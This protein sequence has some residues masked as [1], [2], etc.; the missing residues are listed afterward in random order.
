MLLLAAQCKSGYVIPDPVPGGGSGQNTETGNTDVVEPVGE[1]T[2][3]TYH[4]GLEADGKDADTYSLIL[5]R[6]YNYETPDNSGEHAGNPFR[7][8]RQS[9]DQ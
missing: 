6:G 3:P 8:I 5:A 1:D 9:Y 7:H 2:T 4:F